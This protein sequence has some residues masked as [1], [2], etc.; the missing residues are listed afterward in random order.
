MKFNEKTF[1]FNFSTPTVDLKAS[2]LTKKDILTFPLLNHV[3]TIDLSYNSIDSSFDLGVLYDKL[4]K[5]R[6][7]LL[8]N[9]KFN[10]TWKIKIEGAGGNIFKDTKYI[11]LEKLSLNNNQL[12]RV[13]IETELPL[14]KVLDLSANHL[15]ELKGL[16]NIRQLI[17]LNLS[18]NQLEELPNDLTLL[19]SLVEL[20]ISF[21]CLQK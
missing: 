4:P 14:L 8:E 17:T 6:T 10:K 16:S 9:N 19:Q 2:N 20:N 21:N 15:K 18:N 11:V 12:Q 3:H 1:T 13:F 5:L 7:L